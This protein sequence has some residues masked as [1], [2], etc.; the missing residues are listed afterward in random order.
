MG[1]GDAGTGWQTVMG[2]EDL[3]RGDVTIPDPTIRPKT[4]IERAADI[5][6]Q[7]LV[8]TFLEGIVVAIEYERR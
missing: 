5:E 7:D 1:P 4:A 3:E 6:S 8:L 2:A